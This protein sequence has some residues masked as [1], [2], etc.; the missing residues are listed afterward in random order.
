M[1]AIGDLTPI[2]VF[3]VDSSNH[4]LGKT[5]ITSPVIYYQKPGGAP[6]AAVGFIWTE[7]SAQLMPGWY[8]LT[9]IADMMD[10]I[11]EVLCSITA[12]GADF[13]PLI[14][15]VGGDSVASDSPGVIELL[16]RIPDAVAGEE[17]GLAIVGSEMNLTNSYTNDLD[18][19][20]GRLLIDPSHKISVNENGEVAAT[21]TAN[22]DVS[23]ALESYGVPTT[24]H[25]N[26]I[27]NSTNEVLER[28]PSGEPGVDGVAIVGSPMTERSAYSE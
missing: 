27:K 9:P 16:T 25:I 1:P 5:G 21:A 3:M 14:I 13:S 20:A 18:A 22:V 19:F 15:K 7:V 6:V 23:G 12:I 4:F 17:G 28:L 2:G 11:G 24:T 8:R 26:E 10:T